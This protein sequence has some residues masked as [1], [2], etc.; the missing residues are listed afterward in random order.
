M[1]S[2]PWTPDE[3]SMA[4]YID[5][6]DLPLVATQKSRVAVKSENRSHRNQPLTGLIRTRKFRF[7]LYNVR[8][9]SI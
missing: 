1:L 9:R 8:P 2:A 3:G 4:N 6:Y 7:P 5:C